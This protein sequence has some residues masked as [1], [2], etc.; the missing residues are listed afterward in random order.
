MTPPASGSKVRVHG[1]DGNAASACMPGLQ[2]CFGLLATLKRQPAYLL[3]LLQVGPQRRKSFCDMLQLGC[4]PCD[5]GAGEGAGDAV[6]AG[7]PRT[8]GSKRLSRMHCNAQQGAHCAA[9]CLGRRIV[10]IGQRLPAEG[11]PVNPEARMG[12]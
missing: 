8:R 10:F 9:C 5:R 12:L 3:L 6:S 2:S 11:M 7:Q 4:W 1:I